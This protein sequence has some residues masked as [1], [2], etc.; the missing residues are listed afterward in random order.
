[1]YQAI[2]ISWIKSLRAVSQNEW[3]ELSPGYNLK[4]P[5]VRFQRMLELEVCSKRTP[6][7]IRKSDRSSLRK[8]AARFLCQE[9]GV[10]YGTPGTL[11]RIVKLLL[12]A[13]YYYYYYYFIYLNSLLLLLLLL[14]HIFKQP[15]TIT[16]TITSLTITI[17][18]TITSQT[19]TIT[20]PTITITSPF[21]YIT[22]EPNKHNT[23]RL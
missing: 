19:I 16:I 15:I 13:Y 14:R 21:Y 3:E 2:A 6:Q 1:M 22:V 11:T 7:E 5:T 12:C 8:R 20:F 9:A 10:N 23:N 17:T 18:I 4:D